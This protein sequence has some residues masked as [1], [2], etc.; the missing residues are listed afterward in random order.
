M[1][2]RVIKRALLTVLPINEHMI[3]QNTIII[4]VFWGT[5]YGSAHVNRA[6]KINVGKGV[7][8]RVEKKSFFIP[9][10]SF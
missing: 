6:G 2:F 8:R 3:T 4:Y 5:E 1:V 7:T 10:R 9:V